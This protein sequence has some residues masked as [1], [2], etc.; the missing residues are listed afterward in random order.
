M[1]HSEVPHVRVAELEHLDA[2]RQ[3][4]EHKAQWRE[5]RVILHLYV[6]LLELVLPYDVATAFHAVA[7]QREG[8]EEVIEGGP[9]VGSNMKDAE[10]VTQSRKRVKCCAVE[11]IIRSME[12]TFTVLLMSR[13]WPSSI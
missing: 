5:G 12:I 11:R 8:W 4:I 10:V 13:T 7:V 9:G 1:R 6:V 2:R 3:V